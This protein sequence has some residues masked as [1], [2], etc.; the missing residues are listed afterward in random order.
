[1]A[2]FVKI[3]KDVDAITEF[4]ARQ[5]IQAAATSI[6]ER[7]QFTLALAGGSTPKPLYTLLGTTYRADI[8][9]S[10]THL[11]W[12]DERAVPPDHPDSNF[13]MVQGALLE[14]IPH[15]AGIHRVMGE[16]EPSQAAARYEQR[17]R[18][19]FKGETS[20][21]DMILLGM[22]DDGHT[23]SLFPH[24]SALNESE[25]WVVANLVPQLDTWRITLTY[26]V[27]N[28]AR[29]VIFMVAGTNKAAPLYEVLHGEPRPFDLPSQAV[30]PVSGDMTWVV[31]YP[32]GR[33][34]MNA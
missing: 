7:G 32:A 33:K 5:I 24:T 22:G 23:A 17:L 34:L 10:K 15:P 13:R 11:F 31:D 12:G 25:K 26:P 1:M 4:V 9:W 28:Q 27:L 14:R 21:F 20:R 18:E 3:L 6:A 19:I 8:D 29:Q 2:C 16:L 30:N